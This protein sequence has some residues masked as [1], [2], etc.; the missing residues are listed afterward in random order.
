MWR[1]TSEWARITGAA[2]LSG[3]A[4]LQKLKT[5]DP[6]GTVFSTACSVF[7]FGD[8]DSSMAPTLGCCPACYDL[9]DSF[10]RQARR[11]DTRQR[12]A[13]TIDGLVDPKTKQPIRFTKKILSGNTPHMF[14]TQVS[15][16]A[17]SLLL[18]CRLMFNI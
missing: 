7:S 6:N 12:E 4:V 13:I 11:E 18:C 14:L 9:R 3:E 10:F 17:L 2:M 16:F 1:D 5:N 15:Y 8:G